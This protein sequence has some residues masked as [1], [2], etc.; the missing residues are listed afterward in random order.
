MA[1]G[2]KSGPSRLDLRRE[3]E[4]VE[5]RDREEGDETAEV[6]EVE[7][8]DDEDEADEPEA[9][10]AEV[11]DDAEDGD[12]DDESPKPKK[13][14]KAKAKVKAPAKAKAPAKP[15][16]ARVKEVPRMK[17]VWVVY[18]N[19]GK[20]Q[21]EFPYNQKGEAE[22]LLARKIEEKKQT[23]YLQMIKQPIEA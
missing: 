11:A 2:R 20:S 10:A 7:V 17:A 9:E 13:K 5:A 1:R 8:D 6:E 12:D 4:A 16:K 18:D 22:A 19:S 14:A 3:N 15:R 23:F 21:G